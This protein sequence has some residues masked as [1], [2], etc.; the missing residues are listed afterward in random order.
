M[1]GQ[2]L[3]GTP[4]GPPGQRVR[5]AH[6]DSQIQL[7]NST[8]KLSRRIQRQ[9]STIPYCTHVVNP[10]IKTFRLTTDPF[11]S[12]RG[13]ASPSQQLKF[14]HYAQPSR[15]V[16]IVSIFFAQWKPCAHLIS[17]RAIRAIRENHSDPAALNRAA[18]QPSTRHYTFNASHS[19]A[20]HNSTPIP[21]VCPAP[22]PHKRA[23]HDGNGPCRN[24]TYN[25]AIKSRLLCQLS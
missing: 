21:I 25:L 14:S 11:L 13:A 18:T 12:G 6:P 10:S 17:L 7:S 16:S 4:N 19:I 3:S 24:R 15:R 8:F 22:S 1:F 23:Q 9:P 20:L 5:L 2:T